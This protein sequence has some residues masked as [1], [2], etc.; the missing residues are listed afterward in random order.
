MDRLWV[1]LYRKLRL[2]IR[3]KQKLIWLLNPKYCLGVLAFIPHPDQPAR[4]LLADHSYRGALSWSLPGGFAGKNELPEMA[5]QREVQEELGVKVTVERLLHA[6][7]SEFGI[8]LDLV[9]LCRLDDHLPEFHLSQE[10]RGVKFFDWDNLP[11][12]H[13]YRQHVELVYLLTQL[14]TGG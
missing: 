12:Q 1:T 10:V 5:I 11:T 2:P 6:A 8:S 7:P 9:Y 14:Y 4:V 13:M 3:I